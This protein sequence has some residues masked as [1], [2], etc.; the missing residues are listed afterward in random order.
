MLGSREHTGSQR[1]HACTS[2][3]KSWQKLWECKWWGC[4]CSSSYQIPQW[5]YFCYIFDTFNTSTF[6]QWCIQAFPSSTKKA[7]TKSDHPICFQRPWHFLQCRPSWSFLSSMSTSHHLNRCSLYFLWRS[8]GPVIV[9]DGK[10]CSSSY[11]TFWTDYWR[12]TVE[13]GQQKGWRNF[14]EITARKCDWYC[15]WWM[16]RSTKRKVRWSLCQYWLQ[17]EFCLPKL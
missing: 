9:Q 14:E 10:N 8:Q 2:C 15:W 1:S 17:S 16:E 12:R 3:Q 13:C 5:K 6:I 7:K 4:E 11:L